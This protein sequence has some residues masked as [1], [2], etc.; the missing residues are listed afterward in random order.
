LKK[1]NI[2]LIVT[3]EVIPSYVNNCIQILLDLENIK[4]TIIKVPKTKQNLSP[5]QIVSR[6]ILKLP[7]QL[8]YT[9]IIENIID[10]KNVKLELYDFFLILESNCKIDFLLKYKFY[11]INIIENLKCNYSPYII[12]NILNGGYFFTVSILDDVF[13]PLISHNYKTTRHS[14]T[15]SLQQ[16]LTAIPEIIIDFIK[17]YETLKLIKFDHKTEHTIIK[18]KSL[19]NITITTFTNYINHKFKILFSNTVWNIGFIDMPI[20]EIAFGNERKINVSWEPEEKPNNFKADPF[21]ISI[22][23][24]DIYLYEYYDFNLK[25][26]HLRV[27]SNKNPKIEE[28]ILE[29]EYHLSYP[30]LLQYHNEWYCIPEQCESNKIDLYKLDI[31]NK[32]LIFQSTILENISAVDPTILFAYNKWW[33]FCTKSEK[34][35]ADLKLFLYYSDNLESNWKP[36]PLN[37]VKTDIC[38]ARPA[39]TPFFHEGKIIRP[40]QDSSRSY[41]GSIKLNEITILSENEY[42]E[43]YIKTLN[44]N[45]FG[46]RYTNGIHT[47]SKVGNKTIIDGK[48]INYSFRNILIKLTNG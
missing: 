28:V 27:K 1:L 2:G 30:Y 14:Y 8:K 24:E 13:A 6:K 18:K 39:G 47:I 5:I 26:G 42:H 34:K 38:S 41:G 21:G 46:D 20:N 3:S 35:G 23:E 48:R 44:P 37:P 15:K 29:K 4:I 40:S 32:K 9:N 43:V 10:K 19:L 12:E 25:K 22:N 31:L 7:K 11:H 16:A 17:N 36:H 45:I 33:L